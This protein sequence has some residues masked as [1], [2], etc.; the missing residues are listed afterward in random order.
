MTQS[1]FAQRIPERVPKVLRP[2]VY[3]EFRTAQM[4]EPDAAVCATF[5]CAELE[6]MAFCSGHAKLIQFELDKEEQ[7]G[8]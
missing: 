7:N 3:C 4:E 1:P 5:A 2:L 8:G 6:G